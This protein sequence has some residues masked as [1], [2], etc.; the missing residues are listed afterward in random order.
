[1]SG[2]TVI[3]SLNM[4]MVVTTPKVPVI[5]ETILGSGFMT[6]PGGKGANQAVA[7]KVAQKLKLL[8]IY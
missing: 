4:D 1:M 2:I 8:L 6:A 5:G 7:P 3:G